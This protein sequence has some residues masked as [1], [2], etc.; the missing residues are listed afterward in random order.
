MYQCGQTWSSNPTLLSTDGTQ[1]MGGRLL[2]PP[3]GE[4]SPFG[5]KVAV[6][7]G[8]P[9]KKHNPS[10][11]HRGKPGPTPDTRQKEFP[12]VSGAGAHDG[13]NS[14]YSVRRD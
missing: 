13:V 1:K 4:I 6:F 7:V 2:L 14:D 9:A 3:R 5:A 8:V 10:H 11:L 12:S